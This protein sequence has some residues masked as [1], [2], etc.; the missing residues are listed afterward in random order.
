MSFRLAV[1]AEMVLL[2]LPIVERVRRL[3]EL[4]F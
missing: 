2:D 1:S 3:D 4:G